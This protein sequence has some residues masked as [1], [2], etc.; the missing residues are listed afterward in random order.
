M[1]N[2]KKMISVL[3]LAVILA[4]CT[5]AYVK[6]QNPKENVVTIGE[7]SFSKEQLFSMMISQDP[8]SLVI[9]MAKRFILDDEYPVDDRVREKAQE[10]LEYV[11]E[12]FGEA[13]LT[14]IA[15]YGFVNEQDYLDRALI[16]SAQE[17]LL[18]EKYI[19]ENFD[20]ITAKYVPRKARIIEFNELTDASDALEAIKAGANVEEVASEF[21]TSTVFKGELNLYHNESGL[22][23]AVAEFI[24]LSEV[25]TLSSAPIQ[26]S[27]TGKY[28]VVQVVEVVATRFKEEIID[29]LSNLNS[30][31]QLMFI[32]YFKQGEFNVYDKKIFDSVFQSYRDYLPNR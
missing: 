13:F 4:G 14:N 16:P 25:P 12:I 21:S 9:E 1:N 15:L 5:D 10:E 7:R 2:M 30:I 22:P 32:D 26:Q 24:N 11:K 18:T 23:S 17:A 8:G 28:Y 31:N 19:D 6:V 29:N 20:M 3:T 27:S